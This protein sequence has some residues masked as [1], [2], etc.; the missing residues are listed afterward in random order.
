[1]WGIPGVT[2]NHR[3]IVVRNLLYYNHAALS[4]FDLLDSRWNQ[5]PIL[6]V[7]YSQGNWILSNALSGLRAVRCGA[8]V[9]PTTVHAFGLAP[10][11]FFWPEGISLHLYA[12]QYDLIPKLSLGA[13]STGDT[14]SWTNGGFDP[15]YWHSQ[16][17]YVQQSQF[18]RDLRAQ[19][20]LNPVVDFPTPIDDGTG[21]RNVRSPIRGLR[22]NTGVSRNVGVTNTAPN[23]GSVGSYGGRRVDPRTLMPMPGKPPVRFRP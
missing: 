11:N 12:N 1:L 6:A 7:G 21:A 3:R 17:E 8:N 4:Y 23:V 9:L 13:G 16:E 2:A 18:V 22:P 10:P 14:T 19:L 5:Q 20:G 15:H